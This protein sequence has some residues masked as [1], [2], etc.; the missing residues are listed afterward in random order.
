MQ[1]AGDRSIPLLLDVDLR[2]RYPS[3]GATVQDVRFQLGRGEIVGLAG[4]SGS[5]K[6]TVALA[7]MGLVGR[8]GGIATGRVLFNGRDLLDCAY[9]EMRNIRGR[10]LSLLLQNPA[11]AL[12]PGLR[13]RKQFMEAWRA[14]SNDRDGWIRHASETLAAVGIAADRAFFERRPRELSIGMA[15]RTLLA[16]SLLHRPQLLIADEPTSSLDVITQSE[17]LSLF[18]SLNRTYGL[19]LL[20]ISHDILSLVSICDRIAVMRQGTIVEIAAARDILLNPAHPYTKQI[21]AALPVDILRS[22]AEP[23]AAP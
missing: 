4:E 5:G 1:L 9:A 22:L 13:L 19:A 11:S 8:R 16:M 18:R 15:Q 12:N 10:E 7:I 14:H 20:L 2:V 17:V 23:R 6:S 3:S 21:V